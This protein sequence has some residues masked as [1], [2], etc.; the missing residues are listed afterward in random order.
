MVGVA[1]LG[2]E[3]AVE[4]IAREGLAVEWV[5]AGIVSVC[6]GVVA[7]RIGR[8]L[9]PGEIIHDPERRR[10]AE[11][12]AL[13]FSGVERYLNVANWAVLA[14]VAIVMWNPLDS[15]RFQVVI[16]RHL[17]LALPA[18]LLLP[19]A[20]AAWERRQVLAAMLEDEHKGFTRCPDCGGAI[21]DKSTAGQCEACG[22]AYSP[23]SLKQDW[24]DIRQARFLHLSRWKP[25]TT[26]ADARL[27]KLD[28]V[29]SVLV[30]DAAVGM[31][32]PFFGMML[33]LQALPSLWLRPLPSSLFVPVF[34]GLP[35]AGTIV[36]YVWAKRR[37]IRR[38]EQV[39]PKGSL[40]CPDCY[41]SLAGHPEGGTCPECGYS[42]TPAS[43][44]EDW[45]AIRELLGAPRAK[46]GLPPEPHWAY[47]LGRWVRG[48][49]VLATVYAGIAA[50][51]LVIFL[52][53]LEVPP[54]SFLL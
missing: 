26:L 44:A 40:V 6:V 36:L 27:D 7:E 49:R 1:S 33:L 18:I 50:M 53:V 28:P 51:L 15:E 29:A 31:F 9:K 30:R 5:L 19:A 17:H 10:R 39:Q 3:A 47:E 2:V 23:E 35:F 45:R 46:E 32:V 24:A 52:A 4:D 14:F 20:Q 54:F 25:R 34:L 12:R 38:I 16:E 22:H 48:H 21:S 42:F 43:L 37:A 41:Y 8:R 11:E 13:R